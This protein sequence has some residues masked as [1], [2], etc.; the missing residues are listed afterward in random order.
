MED[1]YKTEWMEKLANSLG[2]DELPE[3]M[4]PHAERLY[5]E[6]VYVWQAEQQMRAIFF[7]A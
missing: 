3:E 4:K 6:V 1:F 5:A 2:F 7:K